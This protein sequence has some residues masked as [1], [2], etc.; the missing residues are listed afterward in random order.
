[1][2]KYINDGYQN[3]KNCRSVEPNTTSAET[4]RTEAYAESY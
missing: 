4:F 2:T 3:Q 1:M